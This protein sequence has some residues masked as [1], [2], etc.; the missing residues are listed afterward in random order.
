[1][2]VTKITLLTDR[3][4]LKDVQNDLSSWF[5]LTIEFLYTKNYRHLS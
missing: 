4:G 5:A 2:L 1:M 3:N